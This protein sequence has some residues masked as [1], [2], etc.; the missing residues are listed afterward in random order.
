MKK[1]KEFIWT[2]ECL[3]TWETI[4]H[5]YVEAQILIVPNWEKEFIVHMDASNLVVG[6]MLA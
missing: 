3:K 2:Q 1:L 6:A 4:K 5:K